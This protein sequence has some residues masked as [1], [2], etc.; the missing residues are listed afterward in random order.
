MVSYCVTMRK[1]E[2]TTSHP[3]PLKERGD[4]APQKQR[5]KGKGSLVKRGNTYFGRWIVAGKI[6]TKSL[7]TSNKRQAE[8][9][10][11]KEMRHY[12]LRDEAASLQNAIVRLG[13]VKAEIQRYEDEK[14]ALAFKDAFALF[15][16]RMGRTSSATMDMY[17]SQFGRLVEW[18]K[19][20]APDVGELRQLNRE[21][22]AKFLHGIGEK[23]SANTH[24]KYLALMRLMWKKLAREIRAKD[25]AWAEFERRGDKRQRGRR[26]LSVEEL[27]KVCASLEG[28]MR[29]LF[30]LGIYTGLRLGDCALLKWDSIDLGRGLIHVLPRKTAKAGTLVTM[31]LHPS[32]QA[33]LKDAPRT[34]GSPYVLPI[35]A[36]QYERDNSSLVSK[37]QDLFEKVGIATTATVD[38]YSR[39]VTVVGFHSLRHTFVS[40]CGNGGMPLAYVQSIVGHA[41]PMM[42]SHYFHGDAEAH[43]QQLA[44]ALPDVIDIAAEQPPDSAILEARPPSGSGLSAKEP[45]CS[46]GFK[47]ARRIV[48]GLSAEERTR[49]VDYIRSL[50]A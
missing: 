43:R 2:N 21:T 26:A 7:K 6:H 8:E 31:S 46:A 36:K 20:N 5:A 12:V 3:A 23:F 19:A 9:R 38:G 14:P 42:T 13:G 15:R 10:L 25:D 17:E 27:A 22:A 45:P 47:E 49:L 29:I 24:N 16:E 40:L 44:D 35:T 11:A 41:S 37:I 18:L 34:E 33:V 28:E 30:A 32:L 48:D 50:K 1:S 39:K 4:K